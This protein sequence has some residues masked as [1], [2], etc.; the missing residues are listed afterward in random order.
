MLNAS[1]LI[2]IKKRNESKLI[3]FVH[4]KPYNILNYYVLRID[5]F[6]S[7]RAESVT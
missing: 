2:I 5:R 3:C 7:A 4:Y 6:S 1:K